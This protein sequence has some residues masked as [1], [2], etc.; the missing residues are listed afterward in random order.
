LYARNSDP[1][2]ELNNGNASTLIAA[3][4]DAIETTVEQQIKEGTALIRSLGATLA[5]EDIYVEY[6]SGVDSLFERPGINAVR[7]KIRTGLYDLFVCYDTDRLARDPIETG[8]VLK[9][10]MKHGCE[11][12]FVRM[13]LDNSEVGLILL[14]MRGYGDKLEAKKFQDRIRRHRG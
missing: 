4:G 12:Q 6:M 5:P 11:L 14:F 1:D 7:D 2:Y 9:E 10:C 3:C 8:L 13:P